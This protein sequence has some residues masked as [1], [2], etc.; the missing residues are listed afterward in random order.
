VSATLTQPAHLKLNEGKPAS[1]AIIGGG[2]AGLAAGCALSE[3]GYK[4]TLFERRPYLGGRA[5]SYEHPGTGEVVDNCQHILL[6][7]CTNLIDFYERLGVEQKIRWYDRLTFMLP[8]GHSGQIGAGGMPAP[9]H[10]SSSFLKFDLLDLTDKLAVARAMLAMMRS[11]PEDRGTTFLRWLQDKGQTKRAIDRFWSPVLVSALNE[12]LDNVSV[13]YG[14]MVFRDAFLKSAEAGRMGVPTVPL[15]ELYGVAAGY[16]QARGGEVHL[17]ASVNSFTPLPDGVS[18]TVNGGEIPFDYLIPAVP[19]QGLERILPDAAES[20]AI[21]AQLTE[22][23]SSPIT[24]IHLWFDR[25]ITPL[26][27]AVLL[28]RNIQW[29][30]QKSK[31]LQGRVSSSNEPLG[32]GSYLELVVSSSK[33]MVS[34]GRNEII[35]LALRELAEFFPQAKEARVLKST[36]VKEIH[37]TFSPVPG[38]EKY[39]PAPLTAWPRVFLSGDWTAT[40]WPATMEGAVRGGYLTAQTLA[41]VRGDEQIFLIPDLPPRGLMRFFK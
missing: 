1:V 30:F 39:R 5:S 12:E 38:L 9:F 28:E 36:V 20:A 29:M 35:E 22:F 37:A 14:A 4:V 21:R 11:L 13:Y 18:V 24:G 23:S 31:I 19:Y 16:I 15:S 41:T 25:E 34:M 33:S 27:H 7:C 40:G 3:A 6:G 17:R 8:G 2:L 10:A 32:A 26:E